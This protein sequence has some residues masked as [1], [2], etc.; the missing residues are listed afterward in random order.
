MRAK[1]SAYILIHHIT[2][3]WM[4]LNMMTIILQNQMDTFI[5]NGFHLWKCG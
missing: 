1:S 2:E 5:Q 3:E 4:I